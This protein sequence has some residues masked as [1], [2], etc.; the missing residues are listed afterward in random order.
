M[1]RPNS[2]HP[3][4]L[5]AA[6][7]EIGAGVVI[8]PYAVIEGPVKIGSGC[9]IHAFAHL[10][11][12][13]ALGRD[14]QVHSGAVLGGKPQHLHAAQ[15][16]TAVAIGDGNVF[17]EHVTVHRAAVAGAATRIGDHNFLMA[18]SHV[19][20]D[21]QVGNHCIL[22]NNALLGGHCVVQDNVFLSGNCAIHQFCR[23]GRLALVAGC[24]ATNKDTPPFVT[25]QGANC[26]VGINVV[27]M[28]R[29]GLSNDQINA[30]RRAFH[31]LF[32]DGVVGAQALV[33]VQAE[34]GHVDVVA[35]MIDFIRNSPRGIGHTRERGR[36]AS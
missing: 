29:A 17:R 8:G 15:A 24:S 1:D 18:G 16:E 28:R 20:H 31:L 30:V 10:I 21:A 32:Y 5:I 35:E 6:E 9:T 4:A 7:A 33:R 3:T 22:A 26:L 2:I 23:V 14:N 11:G 36:I 13:L 34:L 19:A 27:G 25:L 12:P